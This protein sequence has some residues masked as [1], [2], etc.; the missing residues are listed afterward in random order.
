MSGKIKTIEAN[1]DSKIQDY[2]TQIKKLLQDNTELL[3]KVNKQEMQDWAEEYDENEMKIMQEILQLK[4]RIGKTE[5]ESRE[6]A[7]MLT[8]VN[9]M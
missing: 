2:Q 5:S 1:Y 3:S 6:L 7:G 4:E 9:T 8:S